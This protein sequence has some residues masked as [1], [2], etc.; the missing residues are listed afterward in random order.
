[1]AKKL[2]ALR[3]ASAA[4]Q[5]FLEGIASAQ[6]DSGFGSSFHS[7]DDAAAAGCSHGD[8]AGVA[9]SHTHSAAAAVPTL[10][11]RINTSHASKVR[12]TLHQCARDWSAEGAPERDA[13][14]KPL[15]EELK[16][17]LPVTAANVNAQRVCIPGCGTGR[18]VFDAAAAGYAA[19]GNEF[20]YFMLF[21]SHYILNCTGSAGEHVIHPWI[22]DASHTMRWEDAARPLRIPDVSPASLMELNPG[23]QLS[24]TAGD[25]VDT[26][27]GA[28]HAGAW[29]AVVTCFFLDTAPVV[30]EYMD[31]IHHMLRPGGVW[32]NL[33][34]LMYH[35]QAGEAE[36]GEELDARYGRSVELTYQELRYAIAGMGFKFLREASVKTPY[37][38]NPLALMRTLFTAL[39]FTVQKP[40]A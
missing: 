9:H 16:R 21:A 10:H 32:I 25:F 28:S 17:V 22:H 1:M 39:L 29:D 15:L 30:M 38:S 7:D 27:R 6:E 19:Q 12:S 40:A 11:D 4:N 14:Y 13:C 26:Y 2:A 34:P 24:M 3:S 33:G 23:A 31:V 18:L 36:A 20:A 8:D 37:A 5:A 35:W